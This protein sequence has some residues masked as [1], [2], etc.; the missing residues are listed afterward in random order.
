MSTVASGRPN[1]HDCWWTRR[2]ETELSQH[3]DE[4]RGAGVPFHVLKQSEAALEVPL[5]SCPS[6]EDEYGEDIEL[7]TIAR[8][9]THDDCFFWLEPASTSVKQTI[10]ESVFHQHSFYLGRDVDWA[11]VRQSVLALWVPAV[12][13]RIRSFPRR[14]E[15]SIRRWANAAGFWERRFCESHRIWCDSGVARLARR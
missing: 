1:E 15:V 11:A 13:L 12:T 4:L 14:E 5:T 9:G 2:R 8:G 7:G 6:A 3:G 10:L